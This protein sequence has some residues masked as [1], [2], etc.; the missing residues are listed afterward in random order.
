MS[1]QK[2]CRK[3]KWNKFEKCS[4]IAFCEEVFVVW[5]SRRLCRPKTLGRVHIS[6]PG[7]LFVKTSKS[8]KFPVAVTGFRHSK[9]FVIWHNWQLLIVV[10]PISA[11]VREWN[12][13]YILLVSSASQTFN[14]VSLEKRCLRARINELKEEKDVYL[15]II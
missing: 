5:R 9:G 1:R 12:P 7:V 11:W 14:W 3:L 2:F 6:G 15:D 13:M 4:A 10:M 8:G